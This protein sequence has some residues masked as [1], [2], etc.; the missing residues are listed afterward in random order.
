VTQKPQDFLTYEELWGSGEEV[1]DTRGPIDPHD[2]WCGP[3]VDTNLM[4]DWPLYHVFIK[5]RR[6]VWYEGAKKP[7]FITENEALF[8]RAPKPSR[9][10]D[11]PDKV[12]ALTGDEIMSWDAA[13]IPEESK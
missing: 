12:E 3:E 2:M 8:I 1:P 7:T 13:Y 5:W 4:N 6:Q 11:W 9:I 10:M